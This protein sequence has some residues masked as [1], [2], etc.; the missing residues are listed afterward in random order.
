ML[1]ASM[2]SKSASLRLQERSGQRIRH[3][4]SHGTFP[5]YLHSP[6]CSTT[7]Q[8]NGYQRGT[9]GRL[10]RVKTC[11]VQM[12]VQAEAQSGAQW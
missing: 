11:K 2:C 10:A 5:V 3:S 9:L 6:D 7:G 8:R 4:T 12:R 1:A